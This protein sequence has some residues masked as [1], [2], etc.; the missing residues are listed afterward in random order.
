MASDLLEKIGSEIDVRLGELRPLVFEYE[1]LLAAVESLGA[2]Q[3]ATRATAPPRATRDKTPARRAPGRP[4]GSAA[5]V[6]K[7]AA[8]GPSA[9]AKRPRR[10]REQTSTGPVG[11]AVL[12]ALDHGS[13][14]VSE[15]VMVTAMGAGEIRGSIR[16]LL[17]DSGIAKVDREGKTAY[18]L[19]PASSSTASS[20]RGG[21]APGAQTSPAKPNRRSTTK[22]KSE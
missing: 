20:D 6:V 10:K 16:R 7:R 5:G 11:Q 13:H 17:K 18:A 1:Q 3:S 15:L 2:M 19:A 21:T 8:S 14:T 22:A 12:D 9:A 4:R